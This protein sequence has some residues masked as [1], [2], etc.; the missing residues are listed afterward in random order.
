ML[1]AFLMYCRSGWCIKEA[2]VKPAVAEETSVID[3]Y[4]QMHVIVTLG[5][6]LAACITSIIDRYYWMQRHSGLER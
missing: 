3:L 4:Y 1:S 5:E 6:A 2:S